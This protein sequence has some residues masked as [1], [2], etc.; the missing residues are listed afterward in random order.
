MPCTKPG[1]T[2]NTSGPTTPSRIAL[3]SVR[4]SVASPARTVPVASM[5]SPL[6]EVVAEAQ[7]RPERLAVGLLVEA[8]GAGEVE[9]VNEVFLVRDVV[10]EGHDLP[11]RAVVGV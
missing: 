10:D 4:D 2:M 5:P 7:A 11:R 6:L 3:T 1:C 8:E 9:R